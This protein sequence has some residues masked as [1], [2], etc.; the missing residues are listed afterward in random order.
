MKLPSNWSQQTGL[1]GSPDARAH[2][3]LKRIVGGVKV[4]HLLRGVPRT[5]WHQIGDNPVFALPDGIAANMM[6]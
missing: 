5:G 6:Q 2:D 3:Q 1:S 4:A